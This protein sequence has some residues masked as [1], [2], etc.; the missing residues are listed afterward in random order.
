MRARD[1]DRKKQE[2]H[3]RAEAAY[4]LL[5][6]HWLRVA[7]GRVAEDAARLAFSAAIADGTDPALI[8]ACGMR[9]L[10]ESPDAKASKVAMLHRWLGDKRWRG[11]EP[12]AEAAAAPG[13]LAPA[14]G[15]WRGGDAACVEAVLRDKAPEWV[16]AWIDSAATGTRRSVTIVAPLGLVRDRIDRELGRLLGEHSISVVVRSPATVDKAA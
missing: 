14:A 12:K 7:P 3:D 6:G 15:T 9:F 11:W 16:A 10:G 2:A 1:R 5:E 8:A 13:N 4:R